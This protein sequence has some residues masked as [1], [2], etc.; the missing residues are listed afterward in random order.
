[1][2]PILELIPGL[3]LRRDC[4]VALHR[5]IY[6]CVRDAVLRGALFSGTT[7]PSSRELASHLSV[8]RNTVIAA[9]DQ[10]HAE[11]FLDTRIGAG[12]RIAVLGEQALDGSAHRP[13][14]PA[15]TSL[16]AL[17][18]RGRRLASQP[19]ANPDSHGPAFVTGLPALDEFPTAA[20]SRI[21]ARHQRE[22]K[23]E[24]LGY[25][26][27]AGHRDLRKALANYLRTSRGVV[28]DAE[29]VIVLNG[30]QGALDLSARMLLDADDAVWME[31]PGYLGARG[32]LR[33]AGARLTPV[34][35]HAGGFDVQL[36]MRLEP[37]ARLAYVTPSCQ[38]PLGVTMTLDRRLQLIDW[39]ARKGAWIIEDDY[40]SEYRYSGKPLSA[41]QG[42][43][44]AGRVVYLGTFSK[45]MF[46][47]LR[48]GYLV[49]PDGLQV[50]FASAI[51]HSGHT[52]SLSLQS[53]LA[54]FLEQGHYSAHLRRMRALYARRQ[55]R[56]VALAQQ[57]LGSAVTLDV[58]SGGMQ[59][60]AWLVCGS[61]D[62]RVAE[63]AERRGLSVSAMANYYL[64]SP[65]RPG[66][67]LGY[68]GVADA[69]VEP[70]LI[71]L[72]EVL[73]ETTATR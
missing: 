25:G 44:G 19:R 56:F 34:P 70:A 3:R 32:A 49:V 29:Q 50:A 47:A 16:Q 31:E 8:G 2:D 24:S 48:V 21:L 15:R 62:R 23:P 39:A 27:P 61:D 58:P 12:T 38:F 4:A 54:E 9:Y 72:G 30:A 43:D 26:Q 37:N 42:L 71:T 13:A 69:D 55:A 68:A 64:A 6:E 60:P 53:A 67:Y 46:P 45:T 57:H 20:W 51:R 65:A 17:S 52:V 7:L 10:L 18:R 59:M 11:G 36:A 5:Q 35:L 73:N 1:M 22:A 63:S 41:M 14:R 66:L 33:A 28:C 40:D